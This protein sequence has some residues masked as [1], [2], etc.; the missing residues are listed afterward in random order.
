MTKDKGIAGVA[1]GDRRPRAGW[2]WR[3][4]AILLSAFLAGCQQNP[5]KVTRSPCPAA[6]IPT[7][8][9]SLTRFDPPQSRDAD[10]IDFT[11]QLVDFQS[12]CNEGAEVLVTEV[13]FRVTALRR[14]RPGRGLPARQEV[15][16]IFVSLV[17]GG[18]VLVAKQLTSVRLDWAD[19]QLRTSTEGL[20]RADIARAATTPP[21]EIVARLTRE[22]KASDPDAL[23][24]PMSDPLVRAAVR[25][26]SFEVL[27]GFQ[28]D[29][30]SL[31]YNIVR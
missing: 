2:V 31:A 18:N 8:V 7:H 29:D 1:T 5:L 28:L 15:L 4:G 19:G 10:A 3:A 26:A 9:G 23:V 27:V 11:A 25:A 14:E 20:V 16:P 17:Q 12:T 6:A 24:D 21:P 13:R 30:A 22:R